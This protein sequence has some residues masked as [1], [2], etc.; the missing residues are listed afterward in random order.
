[1][2]ERESDGNIHFNARD[3]GAKHRNELIFGVVY[4]FDGVGLWYLI[5]IGADALD[6]NDFHLFRGDASIAKD[7][8]AILRHSFHRDHCAFT[9]LND[10]I[11]A[12]VFGT[13]AHL[14]RVN[15]FLVVEKAV[16]GAYHHG[17]LAQVYVGKDTNI[18]FTN[19]V[20][21]MINEGSG[22][23]D[24]HVQRGRIGEIAKTSIVGH[25]RVNGAVVFKDGG[26]ANGDFLK[27]EGNF[28]LVLNLF[29]NHR[30]YRIIR[31][32]SNGNRGGAH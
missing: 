15:V 31:C 11:A 7:E 29:R 2:H 8:G 22:D 20:T 24:V 12:Y 28:V 10:E 5:I 25:H 27:L 21:R 6:L 1:V 3:G 30:G 14:G 17:N 23:F 4:D 9:A 32:G 13:L 26:F 16:F 18:G 19:A